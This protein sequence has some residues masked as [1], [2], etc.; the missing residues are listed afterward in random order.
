MF[1]L[2]GVLG[3]VLWGIRRHFPESPR[4]LIA[5]GQY[6]RAERI[7]E[8]LEAN[9]AMK[10][11]DTNTVTN[12]ITVSIARGL[13]VAIVA[14]SAV[15]LVQYTFTSWLPTLLVKQGIDVAQSLTFSAVMM[16]GAPIGAM[17][18]AVSVD[19]IGRKKV[20]VSAFI[21]AAILGMMYT[22][23]KMVPGILMI[24]F[25]LVTMIYV[26]MAAI[27]A[28]YIAELFPTY[29]RFR[30]AGYANGVA[31]I[32]TVLTPYVVAWALMHVNANIIFYFITII[33]LIAAI[34]VALFGPETKKRQIN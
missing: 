28:V 2:I 1:L 14:V 22:Q 5:Q 34:V 3:L 17:I 33:A 4:W 24:G 15:N 26:L 20:I 21:A 32:L 8:K 19:R 30:G 18:G 6:D 23:Q 16:A 13:L 31:K 12:P 10:Q 25:L 11:S 7:I 9:G 29:F 27:I